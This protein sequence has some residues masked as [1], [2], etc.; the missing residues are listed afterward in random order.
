MSKLKYKVSGPFAA[1]TIYL[2]KNREKFDAYGDYEQNMMYLIMASTDPALL[3]QDNQY[4]QR[5]KNLEDVALVDRINQYGGGE[6]SGKI[7]VLK[8]LLR[9]IIPKKEKISDEPP[10]NLNVDVNVSTSP[11]DSSPKTDDS[12]VISGD[13]SSS[14]DEKS[15]DTDISQDESDKED[16]GQDEPSKK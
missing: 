13:H 10:S 3:A 4:N 8:E 11:S 6:T 7:L 14:D 12:K 1:D 2:K 5:L 16:K 9:T 15:E